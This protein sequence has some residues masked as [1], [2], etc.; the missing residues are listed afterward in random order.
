MPKAL[1]TNDSGTP[2]I[3]ASS[4]VL[5]AGGCVPTYAA[6]GAQF[7]LVRDTLRREPVIVIEVADWAEGLSRTLARGLERIS[8]ADAEAVCIHLVDTPDIT[9]R[10]IERVVYGTHRGTLARATYQSSPGHPVV[11]GRDHWKA[12][13]KTPHG[14]SGANTFLD[15]NGVEL[16]ECGD[17]ASGADID[18]PP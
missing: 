15:A 16:R 3:V 1:V 13:T 18:T 7:E 17:L 12:L 11:V 9:P 2:W 5:S 6:I 14:D 4:R 10:V 8:T